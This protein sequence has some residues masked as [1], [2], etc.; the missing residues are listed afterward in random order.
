MATKEGPFQKP[1]R[2]PRDMAPLIK[3]EA[4]KQ[5]ISENQW[6]LAVLAAAVGYKLPKK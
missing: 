6:M 1:V 3:D 5:G 2:M 4:A